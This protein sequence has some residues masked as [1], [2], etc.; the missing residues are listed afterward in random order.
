MTT[1]D[2][3]PTHGV[4]GPVRSTERALAPDL[5]RGAM[6]LFI[7]IANCAGVVFAGESRA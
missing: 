3:H 5:A 6:L 7:A 4:R 1:T 2:H